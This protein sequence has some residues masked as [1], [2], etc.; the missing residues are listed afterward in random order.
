MEV[1]RPT[2]WLHVLAIAVLC[3]TVETKG[4]AVPKSDDEK[5]WRKVSMMNSALKL[6]KFQLRILVM[7]SVWG[8]GM[9]MSHQGHANELSKSLCSR[10]SLQPAL[11]TS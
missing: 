1:S 10:G 11:V 6:V 2:R 4:N 5:N 3:K 8:N 7:A 9:G